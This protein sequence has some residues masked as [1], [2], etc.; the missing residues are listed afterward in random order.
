MPNLN[1][2]DLLNF[3]SEP[4]YLHE[5]AKHF[6]ISGMR[7]KYHIKQAIRSREVIASEQFAFRTFSDLKGKLKQKERFLYLSRNSPHLSKGPLQLAV[8]NDK[9]PTLSTTARR[10]IAK[11]TSE[12]K[13]KHATVESKATFVSGKGDIM[14]SIAMQSK[15]KAS[16]SSTFLNVQSAY[17]KPTERNRHMWPD[18][19]AKPSQSS[20]GFI[21]Q[22]DR[23][24]LFD[25]LLKQP[26]TIFELRRQFNVPK[27]TVRSL[28]QKR[29]L[30][31]AWGRNEI[32]VRFK[33]TTKGKK[34]L[35][36]LHAAASF[37]PQKSK[38]YP[39]V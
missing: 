15:S 26:L 1:R 27:K 5:V 35:Q 12:G 13:E 17:G 23:I 38:K 22:V 7:A 31:E 11:F 3:L 18:R 37:D 29:L 14:K 20:H 16:R 9:S 19:H 4:R 36:E 21:S 8:I 10:D 32:G 33:L 39:F 28:V 24:H 25:A 30:A 34:Y 6:G 2:S